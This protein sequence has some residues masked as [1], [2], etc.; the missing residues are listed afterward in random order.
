MPIQFGYKTINGHELVMP[1]IA[2][3][4]DYK[5]LR[6]GVG[7]ATTKILYLFWYQYSLTGTVEYSNTTLSDMLGN[8]SERDVIYALKHLEDL[9]AITREYSDNPFLTREAI[10]IHPQVMFDILGMNRKQVKK[11]TRQDRAKHIRTQMPMFLKPSE[12]K[13][14]ETKYAKEKNEAKRKELKARIDE[15]KKAA[16]DMESYVES[17]IKRNERYMLEQAKKP[18]IEDRSEYLDDLKGLLQDFGI[19]VIS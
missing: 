2:S 15:I 18:I 19:A 11:L 6:E 1:N 16:A 9:G 5:W 10:T 13:N 14:L 7:F 3:E 4:I 12:L 8:I 17:I